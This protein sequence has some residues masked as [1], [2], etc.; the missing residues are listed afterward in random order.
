MSRIRADRYTNRLGTGAPTFSNGVNVIGNVGVGTTVPTSNLTVKGDMNVTGTVSVGGTLSYEDVTSIDSVGVITARSDVS[1]A[2]K[3]IHTGDTNTAIRFPAADTFTVE[4]S[5]SEKLRITS[6]GNIG[7]GL[8]NPTNKLQVA[9]GHI[10]LSSG[11]SI[12]WSD[13]HERIEQS[14]GKIEFFTANG[15]KM[16]LSGDNLGIG[17]AA[18]LRQLEVFSTGHATAAIKGNTQSSVFFVDNAD[19]NIGQ[20]SYIHAD[21]YMYFRVNDAERLRITSAGITSVT[22]SLAVN[23]ENYP[24]AGALSNRNLIVNG[25]MLIAQR[26]TSASATN[27]MDT[28]DRFKVASNVAVSRYQYTLLS[29]DAPYNEGL[30]KY[31]QIMNAPSIVS[32][33][34]RE[35]DYKVEAQ[36]LAQSGWKYNSSSSY[37]TLSFWVR[38]SVSQTY[39]LY[40]RTDDGTDRVYTFPYALTANT[41]KKV[42]HTIPGDSNIT[43]NTDNGL[44]LLIRWLPW[45]GTDFTGS[46]ATNETWRNSSSDYVQDMTSTWA[47][48]SEST[49]DLTGVQLEVGEKNTPFENRPI[50]EELLRCHR[51]FIRQD[52]VLCNSITGIAY[53]WVPPGPSV[54]MRTAPAM[55]YFN[56]SNGTANQTYEHSSG[57]LRT[58]NSSPAA[59]S[60]TSGTT[61][62][63]GTSTNG[64]YGQYVRVF[65]NAEL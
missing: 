56:P 43:V 59:L 47:N 28:V 61:A 49:F 27:A 15:E 12:Q 6:A 54:N 4:T 20:I 46:G 39:Y 64:T 58:I 11:Y 16:V 13:S 34:Y 62:Y 51:Y 36:D 57:T 29:S 19:S 18:P 2:D 65:M 24:T 53:R 14:D 48:T 37:I 31:L 41:W 63:F 42:V 17:T 26:G 25:S 7:V 50:S 44:G 1:I 40:L 10:N 23:G 55:S 30:R 33:S 38:A 22:G 9:N 3:I 32:D 5:G 52:W 21:N 60:A 8:T 45:Y 35:I